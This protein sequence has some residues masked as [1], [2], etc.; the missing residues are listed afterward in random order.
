[1]A[2]GGMGNTRLCHNFENERL[3]HTGYV[4][5]GADSELMLYVV[6]SKS[7]GDADPR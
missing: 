2:P 5:C 6:S 7:A 3:G 1:M 4:R